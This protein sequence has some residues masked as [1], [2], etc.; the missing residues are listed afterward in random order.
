MHFEDVVLGMARA[1]PELMPLYGLAAVWLWNVGQDGHAAAHC[2]DAC[3]TIH[4]ALG[5]F[6]VESR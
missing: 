6:G 4:Y 2:I 3:Q 1:S 5:H